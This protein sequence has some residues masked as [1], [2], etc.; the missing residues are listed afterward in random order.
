[1]AELPIRALHIRS[2][3]PISRTGFIS[4]DISARRSSSS[5][6]YESPFS[7]RINGYST[8]SFIER[9]FLPARGE[10]ALQMKEVTMQKKNPKTRCE[11]RS[12]S[13][14][15]GVCRFYSKI[16][17]VYADQLEQDE[18]II[19]IHFNYMLDG[20]DIG[21]YSTDFLCKKDDGS[22]FVRECVER[23]YLTKPKTVKLLDASLGYWR[24]HGVEDWGIVIDKEAADATEE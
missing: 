11:K 3:R 17:S 20:L 15:D 13:K 6:L 10:E 7:V 14:S 24:K 2:V 19:E 16:Q 8:I 5:F 21:E 1:M 4:R 18:H 22:Y 12:L 23:K 9:F